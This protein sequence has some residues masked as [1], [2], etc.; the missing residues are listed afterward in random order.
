MYKIDNL[1]KEQERRMEELADQAIQQVIGGDSSYDEGA[2]AEVVDFMYSYPE[3]KVPIVICSS[4]DAL[5]I[6]AAKFGYKK[7]KGDAFDY[8]GSGYDRGW[9]AFIEFFEEIG[10]DFSDIPDWKVW[11]RLT[12]SGVWATLLFESMA[13]VCIRPSS[14][15]LNKDGNLHSGD[16][17]AISWPDGTGYYF[18]NGIP[19]EENHVLTPAEK[20]DIKDILNEKNVDVRR[21]LIRKIGIERFVQK[22]GAKVLDKKGDYELLSVELSDTIRDARY[23]KMLNPSIG[24][25]HVEGVEGDCNTIDD[26]INWRA[27]GDKTQQWNP[28]ILT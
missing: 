13:F 12:A 27:F 10:V 14:V 26:A 15:K 7:K 8:L 24:V 5:F 20:L 23:L 21:E 17:M 1:T 3:K 9:M 6:E 4:P 22:V 18:L 2:I 19:M 25:W 28:L 11:K 16:S